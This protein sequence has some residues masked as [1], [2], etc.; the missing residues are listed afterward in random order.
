MKLS[1]LLPISLLTACSFAFAQNNS[2]PPPPPDQPQQTANPNSGWKRVGDSQAPD[3]GYQNDQS[4]DP[5]Q[6]PSQPPPPPNYQQ[7]AYQQQ[8]GPYN[9]QDDRTGTVSKGRTVSKRRTIRI[10]DS[11]PTIRRRLLPFRRKSPSLLAHSSQFASIKS[12]PQIRISRAIRFPL[13]SSIP[14]SRTA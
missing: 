2:T 5:N 8:Q 1:Y 13:R 12:F 9:Q 11:G 3:P 14:S 6:A 4:G 10:T 7:P